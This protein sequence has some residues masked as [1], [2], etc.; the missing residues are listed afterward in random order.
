M[1]ITSDDSWTQRTQALVRSGGLRSSLN[2]IFKST[3]AKAR[4]IELQTPYFAF[5]REASI[6]KK[7]FGPKILKFSIVC[8]SPSWGPAFQVSASAPTT[9][10]RFTKF[11]SAVLICFP[12]CVFLGHVSNQ[13]SQQKSLYGQ[14]WWNEIEAS[15]AAGVEQKSPKTQGHRKAAGRLDGYQWSAAPLGA[16]VYT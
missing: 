16:T 6:K 4:L 11:S 13:T 2:I 9:F 3:I 5:Y 7:S 8:S 14:Y 12:S 1:T 15:R 10:P